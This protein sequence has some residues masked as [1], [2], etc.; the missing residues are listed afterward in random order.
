ME[1]EIILNK[2]TIFYYKSFNFN[3]VPL[4][5]QKIQF[6]RRLDWQNG[7]VTYKHTI[8]W[9]SGFQKWVYFKNGIETL[10]YFWLLEFF[11]K[12]FCWSQMTIL[13]WSIKC[14]NFIRFI[15][16][17]PIEHCSCLILLQVLSFYSIQE[18]KK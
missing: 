15:W 2:S 13:V 8:V 12:V 3:P 10:V 16:S 7:L 18:K 6:G 14:L 17:A 11:H 5:C 1:L 4:Q 9:D